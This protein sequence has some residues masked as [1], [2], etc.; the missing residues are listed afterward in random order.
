MFPLRVPSC[1]RIMGGM[2]KGDELRRVG[3]AVAARRG[4]LGMT[5]QELA[6][7][8]G[9]DVKTVFNLE[10][11]TRWPIAKTRAAVS[12]ALGWGGD[13]LAAISD[14]SAPPASRDDTPDEL[15]VSPAMRE[16]MQDFLAEVQLA[17]RRAQRQHPG[18][19]LTGS[20]VF[21]E[22]TRDAESW[23]MMTAVGW[24]REVKEQAV[25]AIHANDEQRAAHNRR[26]SNAS[27]LMRV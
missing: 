21:G 2:A 3:R 9:V 12:A 26:D 25:A 20:L 24:S 19:P 11:G 18:A 5:R 1:S 7:A 27:G 15:P 17:V 8:A 16:A 13:A 6:D 23:D 4:E 22:G 10:S 14:G